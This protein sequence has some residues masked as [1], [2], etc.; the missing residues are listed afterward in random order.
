MTWNRILKELKLI[1]ADSIRRRIQVEKVLNYNIEHS[2]NDINHNVISNSYH[3]S[4][5][6][7]TSNINHNH[8]TKNIKNS[9]AINEVFR[10]IRAYGFRGLYRG[11]VPELL[12]VTPM[13]SITFCVYEYTYDF[14]NSRLCTV[15]S[16]IQWCTYNIIQWRAYNIILWRTYRWFYTPSI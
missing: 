2:N 12:K 6:I 14:L 10:V 4:K 16:F 15:W 11:L 13:V 5:K 7:G 3:T 9:G 1:P 8:D